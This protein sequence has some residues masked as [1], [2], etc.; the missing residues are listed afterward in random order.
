M[1]RYDGQRVRRITQYARSFEYGHDGDLCVPLHE[2]NVWNL[3]AFQNE[4]HLRSAFQQPDIRFQSFRCTLGRINFCLS[5]IL[6][7]L[8]FFYLK[9]ITSHE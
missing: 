6:D 2:F 3:V 1:L 4:N 9:V 7:N 5:Q 8:L